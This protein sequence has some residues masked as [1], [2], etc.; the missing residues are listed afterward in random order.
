MQRLRS[1]ASRAEPP[2]TQLHVAGQEDISSVDDEEEIPKRTENKRQNVSSQRA[3]QM[4]QPD[5]SRRRR[6]TDTPE[7]DVQRRQ[8]EHGV[9]A[10]QKE[11]AGKS[12]KKKNQSQ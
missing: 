2:P 10:S 3:V 7:Q 8:F 9:S 6:D 5:A 12:R 4:S 11:K 1:R